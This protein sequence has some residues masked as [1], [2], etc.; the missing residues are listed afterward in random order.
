MVERGK[1]PQIGEAIIFKFPKKIRKTLEN[2]G[3]EFSDVIAEFAATEQPD[4]STKQKISKKVKHFFQ[5]EI[6]PVKKTMEILA[7]IY[8]SNFKINGKESLEEAREQAGKGKKLI[9]MINHLSNFD[10]PVFEKALRKAGFN[11]ICQKIILLQGIKLDKDIRTK[12]FLGAFKRIRVY[13]PTLT[14]KS[15]EEKSE[16]RILAKESLKSSRNAL[17]QGYHLAIYP[18][19]GRS[20]VGKLKKGETAVAHYLELSP[21]TIVVPVSIYGTEKVMPIKNKFL[22]NLNHESV[23][24][25]FGRLVNIDS[26]NQEYSSLRHSERNEKIVDTIM[27]RIAQNLPE[28]YRGEYA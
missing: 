22:P 4:L 18:E 8:A 5:R 28:K 7:D 9:F 12:V 19:G 1:P 6:H 23:T 21:D 11:D 27:E 26:L 13:P 20:Y 3:D 25:T 10:T 24:V 2:M 17:S 15:K 14:P 16:Y